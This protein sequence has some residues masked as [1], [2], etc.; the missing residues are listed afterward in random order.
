MA[1]PSSERSRST[2]ECPRCQLEAEL[3]HLG[4]V[5]IDSC[6]ECGN[7]W[8]DNSELERASSAADGAAGE[9]LRD[10]VRALVPVR[11]EPLGPPVV[12][13]PFCTT[14]LTRRRHPTVPGV[15]AQVCPAHGGS[16]ERVH[17]IKLIDD[18]ETNGLAGLRA[19]ER[20]LAALRQSHDE[21]SERHLAELRR[22]T[23]RILRGLHFF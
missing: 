7:V 21:S 5:V 8:F 19:R 11:K 12:S 1:H 4:P 9:D 15:V 13:C 10:A 16:L 2:I 22:I 17:L 18:L 14:A 3:V 20:K 23:D 6:A